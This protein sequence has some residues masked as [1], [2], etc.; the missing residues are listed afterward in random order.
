MSKRKPQRRRQA[1][2]PSGLSVRRTTDGRS[3]VLAHPRCA[4]DRAEDL[5][6][7][8]AMVEAGGKDIARDQPGLVLADCLF[9][10]RRVGK[11]GKFRGV[12]YH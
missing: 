4:R 6:E 2:S 9:E 8:R 10:K 11:V 1:P 12:A 5:E 3:W 7:V